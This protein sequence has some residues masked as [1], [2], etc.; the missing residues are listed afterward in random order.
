MNIKYIVFDIDDT[1]ANNSHEITERTLA[2]LEKLRAM[3]HK[4]VANT[5]RS[6][7]FAKA[8]LEQIKPDYAIL[9]G[10]ALIIDKDGKHVFDS[11]I[12][13]SV[14]RDMMPELLK[15]SKSVSLQTESILYTNDPSKPRD[16]KQLFD[17]ENCQFPYPAYK[18]LAYI[19]D[20]AAGEKLAIDFGLSCTTYLGGKW[21]RLN[22]TEASKRLGTEN[23]LR[24]TGG[25]MEDVIFF[26]DDEGDLESIHAAGVGVIMKNAKEAYKALCKNVTEYT[27]DED[28]VARFLENHFSL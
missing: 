21:R 12:P 18:I 23:L 25:K 22:T 8:F 5:A 20:T 26:G 16:E 28:G 17:F 3:G 6:A 14:L 7:V 19:D 11:Q 24:L 13:V 4:I 9:N 10:G 1:L 27:N 15:I 2:V